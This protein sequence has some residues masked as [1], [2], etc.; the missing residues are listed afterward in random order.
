[1]VY[2]ERALE[3]YF[4]SCYREDS[5]QH[6]LCDLCECKTI[7]YAMVFGYSGCLYFLWHGI[8]VRT[9]EC[10]VSF[11]FN[12]I[13]IK[14]NALMLTIIIKCLFS[15]QHLKQRTNVFVSN[16]YLVMNVFVIWI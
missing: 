8:E 15:G 4:I 10:Q 9:G 12:L 6:N 2:N 16:S 13:L 11:K 5:G 3:N 14:V 1:M 7:E